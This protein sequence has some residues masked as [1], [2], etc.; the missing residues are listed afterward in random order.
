MTCEACGTALAG[1]R[2]H[3]RICSHACRTALWRG[4]KNCHQLSKPSP[5]ATPSVTAPAAVHA[6]PPHEQR[7]VT[8]SSPPR[9]EDSPRPLSPTVLI[10]ERR[11]PWWHRDTSTN[12]E[13]PVVCCQNC[14]TEIPRG[15]KG[16][17]YCCSTCSAYHQ[18][19]TSPLV[20]FHGHSENCP[21]SGRPWQR[22][23]R[24]EG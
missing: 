20:K 15:R 18:G 1:R 13:E 12:R 16:Q 21:L 11:A 2:R 5:G 22:A 6:Q 9:Q 17:L 10:P 23:P 8:I 24:E 3:A 14:N 19:S 4:R 7:A